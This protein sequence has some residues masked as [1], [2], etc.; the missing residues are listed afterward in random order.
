MLHI[1][2]LEAFASINAAIA[3]HRDDEP[4]TQEERDQRRIAAAHLF[5]KLAGATLR[6][7]ASS[8]PADKT[9]EVAPKAGAGGEAEAQDLA[10]KLTQAALDAVA[11]AA[12][13]GVDDAAASP[14]SQ[15][16]PLGLIKA[17]AKQ[18]DGA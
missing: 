6:R 13:E 12:D 11:A 15:H 10:A 8:L 18:R 16:G 14:H 3:G 4:Q 2:D 5:M 1:K 7:P 17:L 9:A